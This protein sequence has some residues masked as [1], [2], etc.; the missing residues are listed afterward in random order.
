MGWVNL[1]YNIFK[2]EYYKGKSEYDMHKSEYGK[3]EFG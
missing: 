1:E 2:S 3:P